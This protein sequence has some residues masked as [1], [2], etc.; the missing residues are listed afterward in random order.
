M[1]WV[2]LAIIGPVEAGKKYLPGGDGALA[3]QQGVTVVPR[4][5]RV[6]V[7]FVDAVPDR[8]VDLFVRLQWQWAD[9]VPIGFRL[10]IACRIKPDEDIVEKSLVEP[11]SRVI[12]IVDIQESTDGIESED[13]EGEIDDLVLDLPDIFAC[14]RCLSVRIDGRMDLADLHRIEDL[15]LSCLV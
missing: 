2:R 14:R 9:G 4:A 15:Q 6:P 10:F 5:H 3:V 12:I 7:I 8:I 11:G 1:Q 13:I